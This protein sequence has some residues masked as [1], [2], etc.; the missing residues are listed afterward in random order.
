MRIL[1]ICVS[2]F[3]EVHCRTQTPTETSH[4]SN[5]V[6]DKL[7]STVLWSDS[8]VVSCSASEIPCVTFSFVTYVHPEFQNSRIRIHQ[9]VKLPEYACRFAAS[10]PCV[11]QESTPVASESQKEALRSRSHTAAG[12]TLFLRVTF[13]VGFFQAVDIDRQYHGIV[14]SS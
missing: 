13:A 1:Y 5:C 7:Y 3:R 2:C 9:R 12:R 14:Q 8:L 10:T 6:G 4:G 11:R